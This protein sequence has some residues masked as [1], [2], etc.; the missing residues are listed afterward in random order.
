MRLTL[1]G[2]QQRV[3]PVESVGGERFWHTVVI[4]ECDFVV[5]HEPAP[6]S[7][8]VS[9]E[10]ASYILESV[11]KA[12]A[13]RRVAIRGERSILHDLEERVKVSVARL[14]HG[15]MT[16]LTSVSIRR[17]G[18]LMAADDG[19]LGDAQ[20]SGP[21][22]TTNDEGEN[23]VTAARVGLRETQERR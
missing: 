1:H 10:E 13:R 18:L 2:G 15:W 17:R 22:Q 14:D 7:C 5:T 3:S 9:G 8:G 12:H 20:R 6:V 11:S 21:R 23:D 16:P 19:W 4:D